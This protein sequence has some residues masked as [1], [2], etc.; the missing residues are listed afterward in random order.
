M[1]VRSWGLR[2]SPIVLMTLI[3]AHRLSP[4]SNT[5]LTLP[6]CLYRSP[7]SNRR[8]LLARGLCG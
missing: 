8:C 2:R 7:L 4:W 1:V 5:V 3:A 6:A